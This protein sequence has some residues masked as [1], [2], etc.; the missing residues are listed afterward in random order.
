I[1]NSSGGHSVVWAEENSRDS[2]FAALKRKETYG[3][4][5]PRMLVRFFGGWD[6][7]AE[8]CGR[9]FVKKGYEH[10]VP[11]GG[12][13]RPNRRDK[14]A[15]TFITAAWRDE[16]NLE[17]IQIIKGWVEDGETKEK[18]YRVAGDA[19]SPFNA[20][21]AV[22]PE[23]CKAYPDRGSK[24]LC[25]AWED[26]EFDPDQ[27]AFYYVRVLEEPVCRY[28]T[29]WCRERIGLDPLDT[30]QC[31]EDLAAWQQGTAEQRLKAAQGA[32][33]CSDQLSVPFVQPVIQERAWTSPIWYEPNSK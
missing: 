15:P 27:H 30:A 3:T 17:Q 9:D 11:M 2:I 5:G 23:T 8:D 28:S 1:Q 19:G 20:Q 4:S 33:C 12:D 32:K 14:P 18:V 13:L 16:T 25:A 21:Q 10:G 22:D 6:F 31:Q 26:P 29:L 7:S 24:L